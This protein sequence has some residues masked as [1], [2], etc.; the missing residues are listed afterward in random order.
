[1]IAKLLRAVTLAVLLPITPAPAQVGPPAP[2]DRGQI[3]N[4]I[5]TVQDGIAKRDVERIVAALADSV[6]VTSEGRTV[7]GRA[8][9]R[10][11]LMLLSTRMVEV[12]F[13]MKTAILRVTDT[14]AFHAGSFSYTLEFPMGGSFSRSG[15]FA[16]DWLRVAEND[17]RVIQLVATPEPPSAPPR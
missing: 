2:D 17:W 5:A 1:M 13:D 15:T 8:N 10:Q 9:A 4:R 14:T 16:A 11:L 3:E 7:R 6:V 12:S